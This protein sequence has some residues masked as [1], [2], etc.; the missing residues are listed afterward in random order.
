[1]EVLGKALSPG[2]NGQY[3]AVLCLN[4]FERALAEILRRAE[5]DA[6]HYDSGGTPRLITRTVSRAG[7]ITEVFAPIRQYARGD[8]ITFRHLLKMINRLCSVSVSAEA[9][10]LL[11]TEL[12]YI[13]EDVGSSTMTASEGYSLNLLANADAILSC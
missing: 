13:L 4:Q 2:I 11:T 10:K 8:W 5:P 1:M 9:T 12:A 3:T 7:F 6:M